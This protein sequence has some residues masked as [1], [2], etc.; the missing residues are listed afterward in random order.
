[1]IALIQGLNYKIYNEL[2]DDLLISNQNIICD[3]YNY[4]QKLLASNSVVYI[5]KPNDISI[6]TVF[7]DKYI[8]FDGFYSFSSAD[9]LIYLLNNDDNRKEIRKEFCEYWIGNKPI[10]D[11]KLK[12]IV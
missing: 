5:Y 7:K 8:S 1:M 2:T 9:E 4:N 3:L 10:F 11:T 6:K 12:E